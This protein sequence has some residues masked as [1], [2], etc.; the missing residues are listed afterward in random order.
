MSEPSSKPTGSR[1]RSRSRSPAEPDPHA[2]EPPKLVRTVVEVRESGRV[3]VQPSPLRCRG[4]PRACRQLR[5]RRTTRTTSSPHRSRRS[6][7]CLARP[8]RPLPRRGRRPALHRHRPGREGAAAGKVSVRSTQRPTQP[9]KVVAMDQNG[10]GASHGATAN[11]IPFGGRSRVEGHRAK[12]DDVFVVSR[13]RGRV[14]KTSTAPATSSCLARSPRASAP[15]CDTSAS[16]GTTTTKDAPIGVIVDAHEN[17]RGL[18]FKAELPKDGH[19]RARPRDAAA[20]RRGL[21]G[22]SIGYKVVEKEPRKS[23]ARAS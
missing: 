4:L 13:L 5:R 16:S 8:D 11:A 21:K 22:V 14:R 3:E 2:P 12:R 17:K 19:L 9:T 18:W 7:P 20:P 15:A 6:P 23:M 10:P 1:S